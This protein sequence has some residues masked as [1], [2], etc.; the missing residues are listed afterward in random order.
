[1]ELNACSFAAT[2]TYCLSA[3]LSI[4]LYSGR[5]VM[6]S[7]HQVSLCTVHNGRRFKRVL[8]GAV[9]EASELMLLEKKYTSSSQIRL[10][11]NQQCHLKPLPECSGA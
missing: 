3:K 5:V 7:L 6:F 8:R 2:S 9:I 11:R 4:T 1:V 10:H